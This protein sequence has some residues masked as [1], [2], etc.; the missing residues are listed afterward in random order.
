MPSDGTGSDNSPYNPIR[1]PAF[2][3][4]LGLQFFESETVPVQFQMYVQGYGLVH[5]YAYQG[6]VQLTLLEPEAVPESPPISPPH[7]DP[8]EAPMLVDPEPVEYDPDQ[9]EP[10]YL[11]ELVWEDPN[12]GQAPVPEDSDP[13]AQ[14][15]AEAGI[16]TQPEDP[17]AE[18]DPDTDPPENE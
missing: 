2:D 16:P 18:S 14:A 11:V 5:V 8:S 17:L 3:S 10:L 9:A 6:V 12:L 15:M 13:L 4:I 1:F 7:T